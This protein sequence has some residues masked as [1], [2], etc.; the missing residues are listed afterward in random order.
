MDKGKNEVKVFSMI[1]KSRS[2]T[3]SAFWDYVRLIF[4]AK[5][6]LRSAYYQLFDN[7]QAYFNN[8]LLLSGSIVSAEE[9][10]KESSFAVDLCYADQGKQFK[11]EYID[12]EFYSLLV[13][14]ESE[15]TEWYCDLTSLLKAIRASVEGETT[16]E[17]DSSVKDVLQPEDYV[18]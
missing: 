7:K 8:P 12:W 9:A 4:S 15:A 14:L 16:K 3:V 10:V 17:S 1:G 2:E 6:K 18:D 13:T 11:S 5:Q